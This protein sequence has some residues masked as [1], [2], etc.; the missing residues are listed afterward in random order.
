LVVNDVSE[1]PVG[2]IF[3]GEAVPRIMPGTAGCVVVLTMAWVVIG[4]E[5]K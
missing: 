4:A 2:T 1:Q 3:R 5:E